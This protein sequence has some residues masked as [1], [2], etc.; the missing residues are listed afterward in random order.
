[1]GTGKSE[2]LESSFHPPLLTRQKGQN[3]IHF[4]VTRAQPRAALHEHMHLW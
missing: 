1:M 3:E 2:V 4:Q